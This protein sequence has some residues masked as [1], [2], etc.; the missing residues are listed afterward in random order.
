MTRKVMKQEIGTICRKSGG[1]YYYRYQINGER[2]AISL[3]TRHAR[4]L[5]L[6]Q[7]MQVISPKA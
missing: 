4:I 7:A 1:T 2:K 6:P 5:F 3:K